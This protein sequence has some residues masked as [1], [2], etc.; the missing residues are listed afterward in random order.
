MYL[1][2]QSS[3]GKWIQKLW[4]HLACLRNRKELGMTG[5]G[6]LLGVEVREVRKGLHRPGM[7]SLS[8]DSR[9]KLSRLNSSDAGV[10]S[11]FLL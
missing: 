9:L 4:G 11:P 5:E 7:N 1:E 8:E 3:R 2:G 6:S 10:R